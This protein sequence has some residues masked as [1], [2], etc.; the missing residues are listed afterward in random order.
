MAK[1]VRTI[2]KLEPNVQPTDKGNMKIL[3]DRV[4]QGIVDLTSL[5]FNAIVEVS[6]DDETHT[7][8]VLCELVERVA[9]PDSM[10]LL[11]IYEIHADDSGF[12]QTF[13]RVSMRKRGDVTTSEAY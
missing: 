12:I 1:Q 6:M 7:H 11:G 5:K 13:K 4:K 10:D 8:R 9:I 2:A 3:V